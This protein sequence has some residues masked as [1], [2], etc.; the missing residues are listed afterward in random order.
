[1]C[2]FRKLRNLPE[3]WWEDQ[4][5]QSF[6]TDGTE[7]TDNTENTE[8]VRSGLLAVF[9]HQEPRPVLGFGLDPLTDKVTEPKDPFVSQHVVREQ[10][11]LPATDKAG[12]VENAEVLGHVCLGKPRLLH[13][14]GHASLPCSQRIQQAEAGRVGEDLEAVGDQF[15]HLR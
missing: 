9:P 8:S 7:N 13:Q 12:R 14:L 11:L 10:P 4:V 6:N 3:P 1:M 2:V 15:E 5:A